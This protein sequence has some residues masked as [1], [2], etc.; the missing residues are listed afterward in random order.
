MTLEQA[1]NLLEFLNEEANRQS[2]NL[3][4]SYDTNKAIRYQSAC[5]RKNLLELDNDKQQMVQY[6][7]ENDDEFQDYFKCLSSHE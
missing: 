7:I 1:W 3:W 5:F 4:L 6:W 2:K